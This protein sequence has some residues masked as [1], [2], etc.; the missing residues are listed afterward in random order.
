MSS[1]LRSF[2]LLMIRCYRLFL[3]AL[4]YSYIKDYL[5][6]QKL[7]KVQHDLIDNFHLE[8]LA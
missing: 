4:L 5:Q 3:F 7:N 2:V 6:I 8:S 1:T